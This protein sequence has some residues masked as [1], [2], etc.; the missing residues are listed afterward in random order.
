MGDIFFQIRLAMIKKRG[1]QYKREKK[2]RDE[3]AKYLPYKKKRK[4]SNVVLAVSICT[5]LIY[6]VACFWLAYVRGV[7]I[8]STLTTC[9]YAFFGGE[10]LVLGGIKGAKVITG[11]ESQ[12]NDN[13]AVG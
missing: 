9:V 6:T 13:N 3:Y 1:E 2:L 7:S 10:L 4:T 8:D 11:Y 12:H 5:V